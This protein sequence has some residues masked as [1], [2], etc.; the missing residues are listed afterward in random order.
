MQILPLHGPCVIGALGGQRQPFLSNCV[1]SQYRYRNTQVEDIAIS[2]SVLN[3]GV[4]FEGGYSD[5]TE[6]NLQVC[7]RYRDSNV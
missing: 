7:W 5:T 2:Q 4:L 6:G 1:P 3:L